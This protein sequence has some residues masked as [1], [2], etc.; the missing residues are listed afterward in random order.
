MTTQTEALDMITKIQLAHQ[1]MEAACERIDQLKAENKALKEALADTKREPVPNLYVKD[2]N[3]NFHPYKEKGH[4]DN[5]AAFGDDCSENHLPTSRVGVGKVDSTSQP[6]QEPVA[7]A[8]TAHRAAYFMERFKH[9]EK[10]LGPN[11]QA[12]LDFVISM[13]EAQPEPVAHFGSAYV[14]ENGVHITTVL[15]PVAIP[16]DSKLYTTPPQPEQ[17]LNC[18][19]TQAR[20]ATAWG[21]VKAQPEQE[22]V[23]YFNANS[24]GKWEQSDSNDGVPFY[25]ALPPQPKEPAVSETHKQKPAIFLKEWSDWRDMVVVNI[26]RHG[27]IDKHLARELANHFQSMT[28][29][30]KEPEQEPLEY[31][32]AVEGWVKIDEVREHFDSVGCATIY[33]TAGEGRVPLSLCKA[34]S[35]QRKPLTDEQIVPMFS[36]RQK[37]QTEGEKDEWYFYAWGVSD[38]EAAHGI[39]KE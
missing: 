19:S 2:I 4:T 39:T 3:G 22:P 21:Y 12:A 31:W 32:N 16:Q 35:P 6:E 24:D 17:N 15:G 8:M 9:E 27:S 10:L 33:K 14:N 29:Q 34:Q 13:L 38:G 26:M 18:K 20:L 1:A 25:A 5:C 23:G 11:E 7:T 36:Q 37:Q 30:P 28:P